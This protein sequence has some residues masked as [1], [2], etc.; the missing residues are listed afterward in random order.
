MIRDARALI[1]LGCPLQSSL[2]ILRPSLVCRERVDQASLV[3]TAAPSS[4]LAAAPTQKSLMLMSSKPAEF[5]VALLRLFVGVT[6]CVY[7][8]LLRIPVLLGCSSG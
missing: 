6:P 1:S 7:E 2:S 5:A 3:E 8:T 4:P